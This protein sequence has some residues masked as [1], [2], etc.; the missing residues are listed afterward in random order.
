MKKGKLIVLE[1]LDGS[2]T[3]TQANLLS[4][5]FKTMCI[6]H[7]VSA[8]PTNEKIGRIIKSLL[9]KGKFKGKVLDDLL[10]LL[11]TADRI[12]HLKNLIEPS[13]EKDMIVVLDRYYL[14]TYAY[15]GIKKTEELMKLISVKFP[16]PSVTFYLDISI[17]TLLI[18]LAMRG[19]KEIF[20]YE[21]LMRKI[22]LN[23]EKAISKLIS[24]G[25]KIVKINGEKGPEEVR[26]EIIYNLRRLKIIQ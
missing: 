10:I 16:V 12:E 24:N 23:Y 21:N 19:K 15:Q 1:G 9:R 5:F 7:I 13:F 25:E 4:K 17:K 8:E 2:G 14:S 6:E 22:K 11:F 26:D 18:R 20:E 3:T